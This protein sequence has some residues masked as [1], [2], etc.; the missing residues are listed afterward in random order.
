MAEIIGIYDQGIMKD[1][2]GRTVGMIRLV[3]TTNEGK[4]EDLIGY[5]HPV[6]QGGII[7]ALKRLVWLPPKPQIVPDEISDIKTS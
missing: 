6:Y 1:N 2:K 4:P 5:C 3:V 7:K